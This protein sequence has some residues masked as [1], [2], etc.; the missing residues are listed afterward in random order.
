MKRIFM[1]LLAMSFLLTACGVEKNIPT[2]PEH[3]DEWGL[4]LYAEDVT[5][6][7]LTIKFVQSGGNHSGELSTGAAYAIEKETDGVWEKVKT[8]TENPV[9]NALAYIIKENDITKYP[10]N[11]EFLYGELSSGSYRL[12]KEI[13]DFKEAGGYEAK[14]YYVYFNIE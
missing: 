6:K 8:K 1:L 11:W 13:I 3:K 7:G 2:T 14:D 9:W 10:I 4:T 5:T 12:K